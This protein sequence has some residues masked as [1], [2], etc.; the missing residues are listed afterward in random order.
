MHRI[1]IWTIP[2]LAAFLV[3][4]TIGCGAIGNT[5]PRTVTSTDGLTQIV[6]PPGWKV[7]DDLNEEADIQVGDLRNNAYLIILSEKKIDFDDISY[8][9]HSKLTRTGFM[10]QLDN[11]RVSIGPT[12]LTVNGRNAVKYELQGSVNGIKIVY[13]HI[14][15]DG[16]T[17]F[18]QILTWTVPSALDKNREAMDF[19][20]RSFE[21]VG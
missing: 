11:A 8:H 18:H 9:Q 16:D 6:V 3:A 17:A 1:R 12:E 20:V 15:V 13:L 10:E 19:L 4:G 5:S 14:T 7:R 21:E 2:V